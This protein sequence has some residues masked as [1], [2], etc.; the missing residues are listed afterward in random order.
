VNEQYL[1]DRTGPPDPE[2]ESLESLL[3]P[4]RHRER[5]ISRGQRLFLGAAAAIVLA[6]VGAM[7][8]LRPAPLTNWRFGDGRRLSPGA[9]IQTGP[10]ETATLEADDT[11]RIA[12]A[13]SSD[14]RLVSGGR[15]SRFAV[16]RGALEAFIWAPPG[17]FIV[18]TPA[19]K[20]IDLGCRYRLTVD[21]DGAGLL[22]VTL[23]WV[24]F[25]RDGV[26]SFI[27]AGA[28][29]W[30]SREH[31]PGIPYYQDA[32]K[33]LK[34]AL[35]GPDIPHVLALARPRDAL[36]LWHLMVRSEGQNR[37]EIYDRLA[38][39]IRLPPAASR[40]AIIR[41]D[42]LAI[43]AA[44]DALRLGSLNWWREWKRQW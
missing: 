34:T 23:G 43:E 40:A 33:A 8:L 44:W 25:E 26:E 12:I 35:A 15:N 7:S 18:D 21:R 37:G 17:R 13:P 20:A 19:S 5:R 4:L 24:A 28:A 29:C 6:A 39:L 31:G 41:G 9:R 27:P 22:T 32:P 14:V 36:S 30:A 42:P 10:S 2:I 16:R 38:T 11:G 1:W 3:A